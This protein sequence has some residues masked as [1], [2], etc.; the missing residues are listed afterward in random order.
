MDNISQT[1]PM[2]AF[3]EEL[4]PGCPPDDAQ[5][6]FDME[7][8][9]LVRSDTL[10][11]DDFD[12]HA[13]LGKQLPKNVC[14]CRWASC[15]VFK[16][17]QGKHLPNAMTKLPLVKKKLFTHVAVLQLD[18]NSGKFTES[19]SGSGHLDLWMY[20]GFSPLQAVTEVKVIER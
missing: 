7:V 6:T 15:S 2:T 17:D 9:R 12:S 20:A 14:G 13:K 19:K 10:Q 1:L 4:P 8:L 5:D 11:S 16:S 18:A 3:R